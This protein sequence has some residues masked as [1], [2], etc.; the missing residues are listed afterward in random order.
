MDRYAQARGM[1]V[2]LA[3]PTRAVHDRDD[4]ISYLPNKQD[5]VIGGSMIAYELL[6]ILHA[7][8]EFARF[9]YQVDIP[10]FGQTLQVGYNSLRVFGPCFADN[11][12]IIHV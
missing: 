12:V 8:G 6:L 3:P 1:S 9:P 4:L 7:H 5:R 11:W 2:S 10:L